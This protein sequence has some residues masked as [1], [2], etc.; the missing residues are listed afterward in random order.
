VTES[1]Q[2]TG[3]VTALRRP[4]VRQS[5][6]VRSDIQ[7]TFSVF[8][9]EIGTWWPV[10]PF[11]VGTDRV[12]QVTLEQRDGGRVFE[13]WTDGSTHDWGTL[14]QWEPP[15]RFVMTWNLTGAPTEVE[16]RFAALGPQLTRV[17]VEH[18]GWEALSEADLA[19][20][21][22]LPG[23]YLGGSFNTG[24]ARILGCLVAAVDAADG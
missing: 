23:G 4:P 14:L 20:A 12:R 6:L 1:T 9:R 21:C 18:R 8:V 16:L 13:T 11:S 15:S 7:H 2:P 17:S 10:R 22:A 24:W 19:K 3:T 5:T